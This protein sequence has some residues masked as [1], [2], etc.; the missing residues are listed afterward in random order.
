MATIAQLRAAVKRYGPV[1]ALRGVDLEL[2]AGEVVAL[3]GPNGAG[4]TTAV[5]LLLGLIRPDAGTVVLFGGPPDRPEARRRIGATPQETS[6][7]ETLRVREVIDLVRAHYPA[8][9]PT[10]ALLTRFGLEEVAARP[11]GALSGGQRRRLAIALAFAGNPEAVFL[12][13]PTTGLDVGA[14]R[15]VWEAVRAFVAGGG[16]VLLTTHYLEEAEA[17][18]TRVVLLH[19]GRVLAEGSPAQIQ[20][21]VGLAAVRFRLPPEQAL[22]PLEGVE[23][24]ERA[25][26]RVTLWA[27]DPDRVVRQLV[28]RDVPFAGLELQPVGLEDAFLLLTGD[29]EREA[30]L[31]ARAG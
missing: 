2:R 29:A 1:E 20:A 14:R 31:G 8:P 3:L 6:F 16:S 19:R 24:V 23:R 27:R 7:P 18:A 15:A 13:E 10:G 28:W 4:K 25:G 30:A 17:L 11:C 22:P 9:A 12:D 26:E 5:S 21:R